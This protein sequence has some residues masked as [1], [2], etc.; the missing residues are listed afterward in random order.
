MK[1]IISLIFRVLGWIASIFI[2]AVYIFCI[3]ALL[4]IFGI[5]YV[6]QKFKKKSE[7]KIQWN[8]QK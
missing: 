4:C 5:M 7:N 2:F 1:S 6:V 3:F 8:Q